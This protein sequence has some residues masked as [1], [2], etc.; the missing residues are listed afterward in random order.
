MSLSKTKLGLLA[1][2]IIVVGGILTLFLMKEK[3]SS[4]SAESLDEGPVS[5]EIALESAKLI[6]QLDN[7][8]VYDDSGQPTKDSIENMRNGIRQLLKMNPKA[9]KKWALENRGPQLA[10]LLEEWSKT[11][12]NA[13]TAFVTGLDD[14]L[15]F[16]SLSVIAKSIAQNDPSFMSE[17]VSKLKEELPERYDLNGILEDSIAS[18][19]ASDPDT[20]TALALSLPKE[21]IYPALCQIS[22]VLAEK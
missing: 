1:A 8:L 16:A 5:P 3:R 6:E 9:A 12:P 14:G 13:A 22:R 4:N 11:N 10:T 15:R 18:L 17:W 20:A 7:I 19:A 2:L 21:E